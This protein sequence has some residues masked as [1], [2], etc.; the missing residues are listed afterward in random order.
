MVFESEA[1]S[2][3]QYAFY[4]SGVHDFETAL[5]NSKIIRGTVSLG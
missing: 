1:L 5:L 4:N 3:F 2:G